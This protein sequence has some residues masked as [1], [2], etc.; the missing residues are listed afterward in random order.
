MAG[1][2]CG[3]LTL[4]SFQVIFCLNQV[5]FSWFSFSN[6]FHLTLPTSSA[7]LICWIFIIFWILRIQVNHVGYQP[8]NHLLLLPCL[9]SRYSP[10]VSL[11]WQSTEN[12][13]SLHLLPSRLPALRTSG[14]NREVSS[15][16]V[17][18]L[19]TR[20]R[21]C[22]RNQPLDTQAFVYLYSDSQKLWGEL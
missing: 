2:L 20:W 15:L 7:F 14:K 8:V 22:A 6:P 16:T 17:I 12:G 9:E 21:M 11:P 3:Q 1:H 5:F 19:A 13:S 10:A 4:S 18:I